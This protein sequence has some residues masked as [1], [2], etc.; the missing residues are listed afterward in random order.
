MYQLTMVWDFFSRPYNTP[1]KAN[2]TNLGHPKQTILILNI[3][4]LSRFF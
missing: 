1:S 2:K 3:D 4:A